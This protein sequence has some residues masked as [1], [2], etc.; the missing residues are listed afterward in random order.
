MMNALDIPYYLVVEKALEVAEALG[1]PQLCSQDSY[2]RCPDLSPS[3]SEREDRCCDVAVV[4]MDLS[5]PHLSDKQNFLAFGTHQSGDSIAT[6][7]SAMAADLMES[8]S[9]S[10]TTLHS[11]LEL[12]DGHS[13]ESSGG[14]NILAAV[15]QKLQATRRHPLPPFEQGT[16]E[17]D[18][19][20]YVIPYG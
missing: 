12:M 10:L 3:P 9:L 8:K 15:E 16:R 5:L 20:D 6:E 11:R 13:R 4:L 2:Q 1:G 19:V 18:K 14:G 17:R 7:S